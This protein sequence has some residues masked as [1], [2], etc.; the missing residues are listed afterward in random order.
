MMSTAEKL[1]QKMR[2][3][4][5]DW[6]IEDLKVVARRYGVDTNQHGTSH[7]MF[8]HPTAGR[9]SVPAHK[10]V[11]PVYVRDF[12]KYIDKLEVSDE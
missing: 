5:R 11:Q 1:L 4:P 9:L 8:R 3:N 10:P 6:R 2:N 7:V 12:I